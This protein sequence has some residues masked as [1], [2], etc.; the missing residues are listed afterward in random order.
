[1][2][3]T[4]PWTSSRGASTAGAWWGRATSSTNLSVS[5]LVP[6]P[7]PVDADF[8]TRLPDTSVR[9]GRLPRVLA[10]R[11]PRECGSPLL[12]PTP[13]SPGLVSVYPLRQTDHLRIAHSRTHTTVPRASVHL[14]PS[15]QPPESK[16]TNSRQN[17]VAP[18]TNATEPPFIPLACRTAQ[19]SVAY[20][21]TTTPSGSPPKS[22]S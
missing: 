15:H 7:L 16:S 19:S 10:P 18:S 9:S 12:L 8:R 20:S 3:A 21:P 11:P 22:L 6:I 17:V 4:L 14:A 1:M 13:D 5:Q 2:Q